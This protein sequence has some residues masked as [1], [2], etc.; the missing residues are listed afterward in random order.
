MNKH[1]ILIKKVLKK[2]IN[3]LGLEYM[4]QMIPNEHHKLILYIER[5]RRK[6]YNKS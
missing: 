4:K 6:R 3:K 5:D 1:N 2:M